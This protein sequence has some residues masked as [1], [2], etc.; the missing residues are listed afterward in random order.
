MG[1]SLLRRFENIESE[2]LK[3]FVVLRSNQI[4]DECAF[5]EN[6]F[7]EFIKKAWIHL[8]GRPFVDGWHIEAIALHLEAFY[9]LEIENLI[10]NLP[11]RVGKS[12]ICSVLFP[13]WV[14][15]K[16]PN[17]RFL[18]TSYSANLSIRD[19][20]ATRRIIMSDWYQN[21]WGHKFKL[22]DDNNNKVKF[23]NSKGGFRHSSC[24]DG[25]NTGSGGD[26]NVCDDPNNIK[27]INSKI[28]RDNV[29]DW[30]SN[31]QS[32]RVSDFR[33]ARFLITQQRAHVDD[34]SGFLLSSS[35][36]K[37]THLSL[38]MEFNK[39]KRCKTV[40]LKKIGKIWKDP[41]EKENE[42]LWPEMI[43]DA[44]LL[45]IKQGFNF[46]LNTI[47]GQL[48]M[49]PF[50]KMGSIIKAEWFKKWIDHDLPDFD[51]VI[52][53]WDTALT[54]SEDACYS[55]ATTWG[56]FSHS[57]KK[58]IML[59]SVFNQRINYPNLRKR[60]TRLY[61]NFNDTGEHEQDFKYRKSPDVVLIEA[62]VSGYSLFSD[63]IDAGVPAI[64]FNPNKYG[65][66]IT[67]CKIVSHLIENG[68]VW[69]QTKTDNIS[70]S[71]NSQTLVDACTIF[72]NGVSNDIVDTLS[73]AF[74][75]IKQQG[76][77][78]NDEN[79]YGLENSYKNI[80]LW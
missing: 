54:D 39:E 38:P 42:L 80:E 31:V 77:L 6:D 9:N 40:F 26:F 61:D 71:K 66:K 29:K 35:H 76:I 47:A 55:A 65:D 4:I 49:E 1:K 78:N 67:R 72:P 14:W 5:L 70:L 23:E 13:A 10:I 7:Y 2:A 68:C 8:D 12:S 59:L 20:V 62:K 32:T 17:L 34:L 69:L 27:K 16:N 41:R 57:G 63:L 44:E 36:T 45:K 11:P 18:Y 33:T 51:Y 25:S 24:I 64:K 75:W 79:Q 53:S 52:Q 15:A 19:S 50:A 21:L 3:T 73:Q 48:Q 37:W 30:F 58:N 46:D 56:V 22:M 28:N 43:G 60:A 74:I